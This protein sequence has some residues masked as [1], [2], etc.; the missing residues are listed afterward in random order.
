VIA[1]VGTSDLAAN[2][3]AIKILSLS[4]LPGCGIGEAAC[5][6]VGHRVGAKDVPGA[7]RAFAAS[8]FASV[9]VMG[10]VGVLLFALPEAL[11]RLFQTDVT[12][13]A[14]GRDLLPLGAFFQV[15]DAV[16]MTATGALNGAGDT[17]Y[18]MLASLACARVVLVPCAWLFGFVLGWGARGAW[19][20]MTLQVL[21]LAAVMMHRCRTGRWEERS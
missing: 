21:A 17:R 1:R 18:T 10:S 7:R 3:I 14:V 19:L 12:V 9:A 20:G 4:F 11:I 5:V 15:F 13:V 8:L 6:L 16:A 2:Q